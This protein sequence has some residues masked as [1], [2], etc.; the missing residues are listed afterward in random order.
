LSSRFGSCLQ[1]EFVA[2]HR[3]PEN[4]SLLLKR[5]CRSSQLSLRIVSDLG[6]A[7]ET[8]TATQAIRDL[9]QVG[10][11]SYDD[12]AQFTSRQCATATRWTF[13]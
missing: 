6:D 10:L 7:R 12:N 11:F 13:E 2:S 4:A 3:Q 5:A 8:G 9:R 1:L